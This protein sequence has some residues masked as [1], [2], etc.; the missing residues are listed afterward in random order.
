MKNLLQ[1]IK[2]NQFSGVVTIEKSDKIIFEYAG[3]YRDMANQVPNANDTLFGI[4]SGTKLFTALGIIKLIET[5]QLSFT[6]RVFDIIEKPY[7]QYANHVT[8][9]HLLKHRSGL[10]DYFDED[11]ITDFDHFKVEVPWHELEKPSDYLAVM[12]DRPM[13]FPVDTSFHYN[14]SGYVFLAMVIESLTGNYHQWIHERV[15]QPAGMSRSGFYKMNQLP[16]NT[17]WG[18][19]AAEEGFK[20]NIYNLPIIGGGDGGLYTTSHELL[21]F[22]HA[23]MDCKIISKAHL[24]QLLQP[25]NEEQSYGLGVWLTEKSGV[26]RPSIVG[27]DAGVSFVSAYRSDCNVIYNILS[28]KSEDAWPISQYIREHIQTLK[29]D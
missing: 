7:P 1:Y 19:I 25:V 5:G 20:T 14:N 21:D 18:Y 9:E 15:L 27:S 10:P 2:K 3:G 17:A 6:S 4:A 28:N 13:K 22:W 12:P 23:L 29:N 26:F 11:F 24:Q 8:I 16:Q